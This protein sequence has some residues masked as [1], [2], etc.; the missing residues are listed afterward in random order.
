M[1]EDRKRLFVD[2]LGWDV[3]VID[4]RFEI[5]RFDIEHAV[6]FVATDEDGNHQGSLRMLPT[7][8]PHIL[9]SLFGDLC[10]G[11][12]PTGEQIYEI[13][14]LCLPA[15]L[16]SAQR[17]ET[18][19]QLISAMVDYALAN[20]I[21]RLTGVVDAGFRK[22]ILNMGWR[23]EPLGP[24]KL[25]DGANLG[26]FA[27]HISSETPERLRWTGIYRENMRADRARQVSA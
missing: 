3:P 15:R 27:V 20:G 24:A 13:T 5:D 26:A 9:D 19:K 23:A 11:G 10:P 17:L 18:R 12:V 22:D 16:G 25:F 21:V 8:R 6:Y 2:L 4:N 14:R 7:T 1:F